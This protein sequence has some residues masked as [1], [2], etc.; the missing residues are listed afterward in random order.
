MVKLLHRGATITN[1]EAEQTAIITKIQVNQ[2]R[3][4]IWIQAIGIL[5]VVPLRARAVYQHGI[6]CGGAANCDTIHRMCLAVGP[7]NVAL[8]FTMK[9]TGQEKRKPSS[10]I[11]SHTVYKKERRGQFTS[12]FARNSFYHSGRVGYRIKPKRPRHLL[13]REVSPSHVDRWLTGDPLRQQLYWSRGQTDA[14]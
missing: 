14:P 9:V 13:F 10:F 1:K 11:M 7:R 12:E 4:T 8:L 5:F 2:R 6:G 3:K